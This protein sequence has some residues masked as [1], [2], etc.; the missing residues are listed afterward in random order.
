MR[1]HVV[2]YASQHVQVR[3]TCG[4]SE[5]G[6]E[7]RLIRS[8]PFSLARE[9]FK[10][11]AAQET[12]ATQPTKCMIIALRGPGWTSCRLPNASYISSMQSRTTTVASKSRNLDL[13]LCLHSIVRLPPLP[14][15]GTL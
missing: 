6:L 11:H 15:M 5:P 2:S 7:K 10:L 3:G 13:K 12:H 1:C 14:C 9:C 8:F 4:S